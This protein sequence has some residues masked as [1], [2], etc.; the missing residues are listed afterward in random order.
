MTDEYHRTNINLHQ[1]DYEYLVAKFGQGWTTYVRN[2][3]HREVERDK[4]NN[5]AI[6]NV[7]EPEDKAAGWTLEDLK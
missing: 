7:L 5:R 4:S 3:V 1:K 2:I 6:A